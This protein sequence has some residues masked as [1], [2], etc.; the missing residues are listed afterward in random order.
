MMYADGAIE[1]TIDLRTYRL[2]AIKKA[3]YRLANRCTAILGAASGDTL[4]VTFRFRPGTSET[5]AIEVVRAFFEELLDQD[6]RE[7]VAEE[8]APMRT[9][10]LAQ[11]FSKVDLIRRD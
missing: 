9:L 5:S 1:T 7:Q 10:I 4:P 6:L 2:T 11:A 8:T 3:A